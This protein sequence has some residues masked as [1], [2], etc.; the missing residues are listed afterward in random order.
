MM[1]KTSRV[2]KAGKDIDIQKTIRQAVAEAVN[3]SIFM[4]AEKA[5]ADVKDAYKQTEKRLYAYP[6]LKNNIKKYEQDIIDLGHEEP[7]RSKSIAFYST[8]TTGSRLTAD[9]IQEG[10]KIAL[11]NRIYRDQTEIDEIDFALSAIKGDIYYQIIELKYFKCKT[12]DEIATELTCD[13]STIRRNKSRLVQK[14]SVKLYGARAV[15]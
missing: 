12:D 10:R 7:G 1:T 11:E 14:I 3:T 9:E 4:G 5:K 15:G 13:P 2:I 6:E 8:A